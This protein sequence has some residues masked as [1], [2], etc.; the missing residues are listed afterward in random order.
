MGLLGRSA[1]WR[2]HLKTLELVSG[3]EPLTCALRMRM[4]MKTQT[5]DMFVIGET[6]VDYQ[7]FSLSNLLPF[8]SY[9]PNTPDL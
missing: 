6:G 1:R 9:K 2:N 8:V 7:A 5:I 3:V 4:K